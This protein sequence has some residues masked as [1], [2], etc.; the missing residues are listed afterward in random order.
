MSTMVKKSTR[1]STFR[2]I[3]SEQEANKFP[4][5][6][7]FIAFTSFYTEQSR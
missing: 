7:H 1:N 3:S 6:S 5:G 2:V 4:C